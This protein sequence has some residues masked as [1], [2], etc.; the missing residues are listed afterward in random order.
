MKTNLIVTSL[1]AV[2]LLS[3]AFLS[4]AAAQDNDFVPDSTAVPDPASLDSSDNST[5]TQD[6]N[7]V[8]YT[9]QDNSTASQ[10]ELSPEV[11][12]AEDINLVAT[13]TVSDN[14]LVIVA[15]AVILAVVVGALGVFY[16]Q[17][18]SS[19]KNKTKFLFFF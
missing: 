18:G 16:W 14:N 2:V 7:E 19:K 4:L 3:G 11:S 5:A 10:N 8:L 12:G 9:I 15:G 6:G 17:R 1:L 13:Q